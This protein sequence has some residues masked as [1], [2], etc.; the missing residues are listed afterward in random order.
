MVFTRKISIVSRCRQ[1]LWRRAN[2]WT[3]CFW[4]RGVNFGT[5]SLRKVLW[6]QDGFPKKRSPSQELDLLPS[7]WARRTSK[8]IT[9]ISF[10]AVSTFNN[11]P[12][13]G[14][15]DFVVNNIECWTFSMWSARPTTQSPTLSDWTLISKDRAT[16]PFDLYKE[17]EGEERRAT[18]LKSTFPQIANRSF[19]AFCVTRHTRDPIEF[20]SLYSV[21]PLVQCDA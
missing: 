16:M 9:N 12:L 7:T 11:K 2:F 20:L 1:T 10:Q 5:I 21:V 3:I 6:S 18:L 15:E 4:G 17:R 19:R 13:P 8:L 14:R